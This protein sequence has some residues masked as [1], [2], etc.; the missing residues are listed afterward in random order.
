MLNLCSFESKI[1]HLN[2]GT[3]KCTVLKMNSETV[4]TY[5]NGAK[6]EGVSCEMYMTSFTYSDSSL[7]CQTLKPMDTSFQ[8]T[9]TTNE[10]TYQPKSG[11]IAYDQMV[12][13]GQFTIGGNSTRSSSDILD[14]TDYIEFK[15]IP[16]K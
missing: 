8:I 4:I 15:N 7:I 6:L 3:L 9:V 14:D 16:K 12:P 11:S 13:I 5:E 2:G 1:I 10:K